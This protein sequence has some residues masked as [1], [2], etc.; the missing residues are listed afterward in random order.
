MFLAALSC[1]GFPVFYALPHHFKIVFLKF[2]TWFYGCWK[3]PETAI[4]IERF[5][6]FR[7]ERPLLY[8]SKKTQRRNSTT[9]REE[10]SNSPDVQSRFTPPHF[11]RR[12]RCSST[13]TRTIP[14]TRPFFS[15]AW[16]VVGKVSKKASG[17][18]ETIPPMSMGIP[19]TI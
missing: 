1:S 2:G 3:K 12:K 5:M 9:H 18:M 8:N 7:N 16:T 14:T 19:I 6:Q 4:D 15:N 10:L 17:R 11:R 13:S